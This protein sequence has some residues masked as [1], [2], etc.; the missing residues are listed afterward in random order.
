[1]ANETIIALIDEEIERLTKVRVLLSKTSKIAAKLAARGIK[2]NLDPS[3]LK[4]KA[5]GK[6]KKSRVLSPEA[7]K[8]IAEAQ[9]KRWAAQKSKQED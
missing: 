8:R 3:V 5:Q 2:T 6:T 7:R 9:R 1:M 4:G